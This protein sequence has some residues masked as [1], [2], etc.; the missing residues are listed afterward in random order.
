MPDFKP[1]HIDRLFKERTPIG[2]G[3][4]SSYL[5]NVVINTPGEFIL[6]LFNGEEA[7][8]EFVRPK[9]HGTFGTFTF[10]C[11]LD[12]GLA[13]TL[14]PVENLSIGTGPFSVTITYEERRAGGVLIPE[15]DS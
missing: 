9:Q 12:K 1:Y 11:H 10:N 3:K 8:A 4:G 5:G 6:T 13:F 2:R 15:E 7:F 14:K